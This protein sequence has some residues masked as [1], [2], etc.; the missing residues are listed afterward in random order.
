[1]EKIISP[2]PSSPLIIY[3]F[4]LFDRIP[5]KRIVLSND[6][7]HITFELQ[8]LYFIINELLSE[9]KC[10]NDNCANKSVQLMKSRI[11]KKK[12]HKEI[13]RFDF[14]FSMKKGVFKIVQLLLYLSSVVSYSFVHFFVLLQIEFLFE[15]EVVEYLSF[16]FLL[17][18]RI[19]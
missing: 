14:F 2:S 9:R 17:W 18:L 19:F 10:K 3:N 4:F 15:V 5:Q 12:Y 8:I 7:E 1:L 16:N 13:Q 11:N 6:P